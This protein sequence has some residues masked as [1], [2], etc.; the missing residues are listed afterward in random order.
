MG[1]LGQIEA[2]KKH[3]PEEDECCHNADLFAA[4]DGKAYPVPYDFDMSGMVD[5]PYA[6]PNERFGIRRVTQRLYRGYCVHN[7]SL[8]TAA[9]AFR[10]QRDALYALVDGES[11]LSDKTAKKM[12]QYLDSF[13]KVI[14]DRDEF[15]DEITAECRG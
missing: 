8:A 2:Y 6:I 14:D 12:R 5:A 15:R 10:D 7:G 11:R 9:Q 4:D 13:Y 3:I 1:T